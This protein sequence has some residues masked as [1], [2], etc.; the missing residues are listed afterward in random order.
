MAQFSEVL[1]QVQSVR[2]WASPAEV[3]A[4]LDGL[5]EDGIISESYGKSL[6]LHQLHDGIVPDL[7][8]REAASKLGRDELDG[9][10][11]LQYL[12]EGQVNPLWTDGS[13]SA[14][15]AHKLEDFNFV[16]S[17][18]EPITKSWSPKRPLYEHVIH[19]KSPKPLQEFLGGEPMDELYLNQEVFSTPTANDFH[20]R[21]K[22]SDKKA[23]LLSSTEPVQKPV[24]DSESV[25]RG[26]LGNEEWLEQIEKA[27][28]LAIP[29]EEDRGRQMLQ[30]MV[31]FNAACSSTSDIMV[32]GREAHYPD[33]DTEEEIELAA[34][35]RMLD[36]STGDSEFSETFSTDGVEL[37]GLCFSTLDVAELN[38]DRFKLTG[39]AGSVSPAGACAGAGTD[40][41]T[42]MLEGH[43][44]V[45]W[46]DSKTVDIMDN[47]FGL[48]GEY[49][50]SNS[51]IPK[52][53]FR[54][55]LSS[56]ASQDSKTV[57][58][59]ESFY[60]SRCF[61]LTEEFISD[62]EDDFR[63][64][65]T[66]CPSNGV[67]EILESMDLH[68]DAK[69]QE[70]DQDSFISD[71]LPE[72]LT[73]Y[74]NDECFD[75]EEFSKYFKSG[76]LEDIINDSETPL[77][78]EVS[79][80]QHEQPQTI[81]LPKHKRK[82]PRV[83]QRSKKNPTLKRLKVTEQPVSQET[84]GE[85]TS[86][87]ECVPTP[88]PTPEPVRDLPT[89]P[90]LFKVYPSS[91]G[92]PIPIRLIT[93]PDNSGYQVVQLS[94]SPPPLIRL[95]LPNMTATP[96]YILANLVP[97]TPP[98]CKR[99]VPPLSPVNGAVAPV[100]MSS[101]PTGSLSDMTSKAASPPPSPSNELSP[102]KESPKCPTVVEIPQ[103]VKD[104]IQRYKA[105]MAENCQAME[106]GLVLSTHYVDVQMSR[107]EIIRSGKNTNKSLDKD[108]IITGDLDRQESFVEQIFPSL[109]GDKHNK[110]YIMLFGKAGMGKTTLIKKLCL[111]WSKDSIPQFDFVFLLDGKKLTLT[112]PAYSLQTL[113]LSLS[114]FAP[115]YTDPGEV[116]SQI[117][118][119]PKRVLIIFDGFDELRDYEMLLQTL[120]KDLVT[121]LQ[122][123]GKAQSFTVKQLFS[124]ILQRV[125]LPGCTLLLA[126]RPRGNA[127]QL[128]RRTDSLL[129]VCGFSP[130]NVEMYLSKYFTDP[131]LRESAVDCLRASSYLQLLCWNPGLC[132][133]VC[134]VLEQ[135]KS[136][137]ALPRTLTGLCHQVLCLKLEKDR[138][139]TQMPGETQEQS[140]QEALTEI[141]NNSQVRKGRKNNQT[142]SRSA[143]QSALRSRRAKKAKGQ[144]K[145]R[146]EVDEENVFEDNDRKGD[147]ELL[148]QL[149]S[150]AWEGVKSNSSIIPAEKAVSAKLKAFGFRTGLL[151]AHRLRTTVAGDD[152]EGGG[153]D[154]NNEE[155]ESKENGG[156]VNLV[157][158]CDDGILLWANPFL[159]SYIAA[160]HLSLSRTV[161]DRSFLQTLPFQTTVKGRRKPK[162]EELELTQR[163]AVGLLFYNRTELQR[164]ISYKET[165]VRDMLVSKQALATKHL[166]GLSISE[167]SPAQVLEACNYVYEAQFTPKGGGENP[168]SRMLTHLAANLPEFLTF[169][170]VS[171]SPPDVF[172][173]QNVLEQ[174]GAEGRSFC[175]DLEDSG[176]QICGL[177]ALMSLNNINT[178]RACIA[179]VITLWEQLEQSD[180]GE[181]LLGAVSKFKIHPLKATQVCHIEHLEKLVNIHVHKRLSESSSQSESILAEGVPAVKELY[182]LEFDCH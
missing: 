54:C 105:H 170:G 110:R 5:V 33:W 107:R 169:C 61:S 28:R 43:S 76:C 138:G 153:Q 120:E 21:L 71:L 99:Q 160:V 104:Y 158:N 140:V 97:A 162:R 92:A 108:L 139:S 176:I 46:Q 18:D 164:L 134:T 30:A 35:C 132:H 155:G 14:V 22:L 117:L 75:P 25:N 41:G 83:S 101:F 73:E 62:R 141:S 126:T 109:N 165:V 56:G 171:L 128:L 11:D 58:Q 8:C 122:R 135:S 16:S 147:K 112:E 69:M 80:I 137:D 9:T 106:A 167:L 60:S 88:T 63:I 10:F 45:F 161:P 70:F 66:T 47:L 177:R 37:A 4:L 144:E 166:E 98:P 13:E 154:D 2:T 180:E 150:L 116:Y 123:N 178:Y 114:S 145:E 36:A 24:S 12:N 79:L 119:A 17:T 163:F 82:R 174:G 148:S 15:S 93:L 149:S 68:C 40:N 115:P 121:S 49:C 90:P 34:A 152:G 151:L 67:I 27:A 50:G 29:L 20:Y 182:K 7:V 3:Q 44:D 125:L 32:L 156:D 103:G 38:I 39:A 181:L 124:A 31:P 1:E 172:T 84:N 146:D 96:T 26:N 173:V 59:D 100:V 23:E 51:S 74:L 133:L 85:P 159:Q 129:E 113:L 52:P 118:A 95:P 94:S 89:T 65:T 19:R 111:D 179:D 102:C 64:R 57:G 81:K 131:T 143:R 48:T 77:P 130:T 86:T 136:S 175:L 127:S 42:F 78:S 72:D 53:T 55:L 87:P 6:R 91:P 157:D 142:K 168:A